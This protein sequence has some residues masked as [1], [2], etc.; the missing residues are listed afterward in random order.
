LIEKESDA[1]PQD[2]KLINIK[3]TKVLGQFGVYVNH[4]K[5]IKFNMLVITVALDMTHVIK[6]WVKKKAN[7]NFHDNSKQYCFWSLGRQRVWF[8]TWQT[9]ERLLRALKNPP[10]HLITSRN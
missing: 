7:I 6:I 5:P 10:L 2:F 9:E 3:C 1:N 8:I 4:E